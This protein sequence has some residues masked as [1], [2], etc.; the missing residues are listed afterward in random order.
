VSNENASGNSLRN[1]GGFT[2][3]VGFILAAA[4]SAIGLGNIW[5]FPYMT[6][7]NGGSAFVLLYVIAVVVIGVSLLLVEF[8]IGRYGKANAVDS[9]GKINPKLKFIGRIGFFSSPMFLSYYSVLSGWIIYYTIRSLTGLTNV[10]IDGMGGFFM[11]FISQPGL[12]LLFHAIFSA[13]TVYIIARGVSNGI[14]RWS[15]I[16]MPILFILLLVLVIRSLTLPGA[17]EGIAWFLNPDFSK[18]SGAV[19]VAAVGQIF[20]SLSVGMSGMI[21]YASYLKGNENLVRTAGI[22]AFFDTLVAILAGL[23]IFPAVFTYGME[24]GAGVGLIFIT[25]PAVFASM[26]FGSFFG[27][28]FFA[29][30]IVANLTSSI[31]ILEMPTAYLIE[32]KNFTR[33]RAAIFIGGIAFVLGIAVS[34]G[35]GIWSHITLGEMTILDVF[36]Y[37]GSN[38][39]LPLCG[40]LSAIV[41]GW[42]WKN[43]GA[44]EEVTNGGAINRKTAPIWY[45]IVKFV[46]PVL[47]ILIFL[48]VIGVF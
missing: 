7:T 44:V 41:V 38:I 35:Y 20:F 13:M 17:A 47:I 8:T 6:G 16:L 42:I 28:L 48:S 39:I 5:R 30:L 24:P 31:S 15:K 40:L 19:L 14:E 4:G 3:N 21:T 45:S 36:D 33:P 10:P 11:N 9:Y 43:R 37:L 27:F 46:I 1:R 23:V 22:V 2:S 34:F 32:K 18:L 25:L 12:P 29:L 26:P